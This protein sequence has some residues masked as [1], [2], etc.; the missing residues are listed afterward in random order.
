[1]IRVPVNVVHPVEKYD[2]V[3]ADNV[4]GRLTDVLRLDNYSKVVVLTDLTI[5]AQLFPILKPS[6][7]PESRIISIAPGEQSKSLETAMS[8]WSQMMAFKIDRK[9]LVINLGGGVITDLGGFVASLYMRGIDFIQIPTTLL[10][11]VDASVG[12]KTGVNF[13]GV[14]NIIGSFTQPKLVLVDISTLKTLP[15]REFNSGFAEILKH[16]L[17]KDPDYF[18]FVSLKKPRE[19]SIPELMNI[20]EKSVRIKADIVQ[21][22]VKETMGTRK[23]LNFGHTIGHAIE[24]TLIDLNTPILHGEAISLGM[25]AEAK[26]SELMG[27]LNGNDTQAIYDALKKA[28]L[29]V[30]FPTIS[31][32]SIVQKMMFD[33]KNEGGVTKFTLLK[34]VGEAIADCEV[35]EQ[36]I[37]L[38]L[39]YITR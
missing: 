37:Q 6:L 7:P 10:A 33:K 17:I 3:I 21:G 2:V 30:S 8:I 12:G 16:G 23:L 1:M 31:S 14:K 39:Q 29:P 28:S 34:R 19:F 32:Q 15:D 25:M 13:G 27:N 26:I 35:S 4:L 9:S 24:A 11:Q 38:A 5:E 36:H 20:I 22:D 18:Q